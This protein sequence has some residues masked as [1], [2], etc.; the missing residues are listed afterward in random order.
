MVM[1]NRHK[2]LQIIKK[3]KIKKEDQ[4]HYNIRMRVKHLITGQKFTITKRVH[5]NDRRLTYYKKLSKGDV[6]YYE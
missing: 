5:H 4:E 1:Y 6:T 2:V 3:P